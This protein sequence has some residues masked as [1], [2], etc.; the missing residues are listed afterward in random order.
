MNYCADCVK[1]RVKDM[2]EY[3][4]YLLQ[5]VKQADKTIMR[6]DFNFSVLLGLVAR[7][8]GTKMHEE[9]VQEYERLMMI[10]EEE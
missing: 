4:E 10:Q 9:I 3:E 1:E 8:G 5:Q 6:M 2:T 7:L